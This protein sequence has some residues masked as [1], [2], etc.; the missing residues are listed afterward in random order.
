LKP[1]PA[2]AFVLTGVTVSDWYTARHASEKLLERGV[3][4]VVSHC[5]PSG[6][7]LVWN[8]GELWLPHLPMPCA[9]STGAGDAFAAGLAAK[10]A[11]K[12]PLQQAAVFANAAAALATTKMGA[13]AALPR[14]DEV[15]ELL[16]RPDIIEL[17]LRNPQNVPPA[18]VA[19]MPTNVADILPAPQPGAS[20]GPHMP[21][22]ER[23][24]SA[25]I[26]TLQRPEGR[27]TLVVEREDG[28][29]TH[30]TIVSRRRGGKNKSQRGEGKKP[31]TSGR[32]GAQKP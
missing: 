14:R 4:T 13:Q 21:E 12:V 28:R 18:D 7:I 17:M 25:D 29:P 2:E 11:E 31:S 1:N 3:K 5:G 30:A 24:I 20:G 8:E 15:E 27:T 6:K 23:T 26:V 32:H 16:R 19:S 9:D 10:L 22:E